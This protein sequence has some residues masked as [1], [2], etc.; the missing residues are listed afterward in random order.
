MTAAPPP[1]RRYRPGPGTACSVTARLTTRR[2]GTR[3]TRAPGQTGAASSSPCM[4]S[5]FQHCS[6]DACNVVSHCHFY[7]HNQQHSTLVIYL[8]VSENQRFLGNHGHEDMFIT[9]VPFHICDG[10]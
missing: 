6:V 2:S 10:E 5:S 4:W 8:F 3:A 1:A 7:L 9:F